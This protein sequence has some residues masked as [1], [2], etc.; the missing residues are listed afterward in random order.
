MKTIFKI[1]LSILCAFAISSC[2]RDEGNAITS[3]DPLKI[4]SLKIAQDT[5]DVFAIQTIKTYSQ[6]ANQCEGFYAYDYVHSAPL[7][8]KVT[9]YKFKISAACA[10][11]ETRASQINF[12]P[13]Q[14]G[15]YVFKFWNG[16]NSSNSDIWIEKTI[17][18]Q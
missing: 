3:L 6:F 10:E 1:G 12:R 18:V 2:N 15:I 16:T 7:E 9:T 14:K 17:V 4:D 8:R 11:T 13:Q 5:M